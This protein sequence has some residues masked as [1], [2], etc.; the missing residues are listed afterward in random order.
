LALIEAGLPAIANVL[1]LGFLKKHPVLPCRGKFL[2]KTPQLS[3]DRMHIKTLL[4]RIEK[5]PGFIYD[6]CQWRDSGPPALV[7]TLRPQAGSKPICSKCGERRPGYDTLRVRTFAFVPLWAI[8]V[9]FL[10]APRRVQCP[11][12]GVKVEKLPW[13]AGKSHLTISYAW[14]LATWCKRLSWKEVAEVFKTSW[15]TVFRSVEMAVNW[16]LAHRNIDGITAIGIDEICWRKRKDKF[17]TLV[18][19]LDQGKRRLLWIG[20]DRTA[21]TF[22]EFFDWL[23]TARSRQLR[24]ICSDMWKSYLVVIAEK[25]AGAVNILD[26][27]HIMS[28][29]SKAIDEVRANETKELKKN[30]KEPLLTKSRWCLLKRP[31]N[32]TEKQVDRLKDLLACNL[33]TV[34]AY[35]LKED[36]Q[37][38][39]GYSSPAWAGKFLDAW[40]TRTMRSKIKPMKKVAKMLRAHRPLL[41]NWFRAKNT[42]ALGCVEGFN[43]KAKVVTKRSYGFRTYD[44]LKIALYHGLGDLPTPKAT[45]RFC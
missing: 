21:K 32:L 25:A 29:M 9:F 34:R 2:P 30:G 33:R 7:I 17:V 37:R 13:A 14:F 45:H 11:T 40:C 12:C 3:S 1:L 22:R 5:Q 27:F 15:D 43:N 36:F 18:Y 39:W 28:H 6:Q 35:L 8:P 19:Q 31:E 41:L 24:F 16:G 10:Y 26:R 20:P 42:I 4:N 23:G 38:F 44:G